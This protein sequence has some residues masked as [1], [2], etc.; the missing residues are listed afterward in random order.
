MRRFYAL[1]VKRYLS[2]LLALLFLLLFWWVYLLIALAIRLDSPGP[3]FFRQ[4]RVGIGK[5]YFEILKFRTM[6]VDT[7]HDVPTHLLDADRYVTRVGRF[8]RKH[9]L[10]ELPQIFN[11]LSLDPKKKMVFVGPRPALWNQDD[12]IAERDKYGANDVYPGITGWAQVNGR[13]TLEIPEKARLDGYYAGHVSPLLDME[14]ILKT[15]TDVFSG[16]GVVEGGTGAM[17]RE[18]AEHSKER[19]R[20][21]IITNHSYMLWQ[22]RRE[23]IKRL[24]TDYD[25]TA[26]MPFVGHEEDFKQMGVRCIRTDVDRR[27]TDPVKDLRLIGTYRRILAEEKPALVITYSIKPNIYAGFLCG[28]RGIPYCANVQGLGTAFESAGLAAFVSFLYRAALRKA[29]TVFFENEKDAELFR[30]RHIVLAG[31][32]HVL[33]GAGV[34]LEAYPYVPY[35]ANDPV[36][37]LYIG[38]IMKEKGMDELFYAAERLHK[39]GYPFILDLVGFYEDS[40]EGTVRRLEH[41]GIAKFHGFKEDPRPYYASCDCVVMPS[42]HEGMSNVN[43]EA[44]ATGRPVITTYIPGCREAVDMPE[45]GMLVRVK[46]EDSLYRAMKKFLAL[47]PKRREKMGK[48]A[49][50]KMEREFDREAVVGE[51]IREIGPI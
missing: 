22:F 42:Y 46:D 51:T 34:N 2:S 20:I 7:P 6:R 13:D 49:R 50:A 40:Y 28:Q 36:H 18:Q 11:V 29:R 41:E 5:S 14:C 47:S 17:K 39:E 44:S 12:L 15:F 24:L 8:L 10:D 25:V 3:V 35:P 38:R 27:G 33:R 26:A 16:E 21:L 30:R 4:K 31:K 45:T 48:N 1:C 37:F 9:S 23:L 43:L 32:L 19:K